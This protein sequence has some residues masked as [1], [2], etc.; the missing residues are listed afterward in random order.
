MYLGFIRNVPMKL[1]GGVMVSVIFG[2]LQE[3]LELS[4]GV[5]GRGHA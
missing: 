5:F 1:Y 2:K 4:G 3:I